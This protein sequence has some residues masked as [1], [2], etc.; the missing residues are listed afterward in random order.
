MLFRLGHDQT[1]GTA[2]LKIEGDKTRCA[3]YV[4]HLQTGK[5]NTENSVLVRIKERQE[6][7][8]CLFNKVRTMA[9]ERNRC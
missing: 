4:L 1:P 6:S 5:I 8:R 2:H 3:G 9:E 7:L